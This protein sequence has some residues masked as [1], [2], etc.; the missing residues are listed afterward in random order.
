[1]CPG[2]AHRTVRCTRTIYP[3][4]RHSRVSQDALR[5]NSPDCPVHQRSNDYPAQW[6]TA[7]AWTQS[8]NARTV[9][10]EVKAVVRGA[11][12]NEECPS[13]VAPDCPVPLEDKASN[14]QKLPNPNG[15]VTWLV[16]RTVRCV[17]RQQPAPTVN[18]WLRAIN[19]PNHRHSKHPSLQHFT[20]NTRA[21]AFTPRHNLIESK[22]LQVPNPLQTPSDLRV[23]CSCSLR[24]CCLDRFLP[25]SFLFQS[26][27]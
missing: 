17:H 12:D 23:F 25:S 13:G 27:L 24:S 20:F 1:V 10:A 14:G 9:R 3:S 11:P 26:D 16:H 22:S 8:Y 2:L 21:S 15:W 6:S 18:W 5:Y 4:T 7:K 19:T